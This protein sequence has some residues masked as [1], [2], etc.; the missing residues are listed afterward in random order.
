MDDAA[1]ERGD[2][3]LTGACNSQIELAV[4][5]LS[6]HLLETINQAKSR[7]AVFD[8]YIVTDRSAA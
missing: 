8:C 5:L 6:D 7:A 3:A 2:E 4:G 1:R